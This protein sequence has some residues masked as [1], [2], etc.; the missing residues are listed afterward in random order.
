MKKKK[1]VEETQSNIKK[2]CLGRDHVEDV[3]RRERGKEI[4]RGQQGW[5]RRRG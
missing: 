3:D 4:G 1:R 5:A 2:A